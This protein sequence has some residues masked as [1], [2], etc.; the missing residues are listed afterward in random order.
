M[1]VCVCLTAWHHFELCN[2]SRVTIGIFWLMVVPYC[3]CL[4]MLYMPKICKTYARILFIKSVDRSIWRKCWICVINSFKEFNQKVLTMRTRRSGTITV[5]GNET[6]HKRKN[7]NKTGN[8]YYT[9]TQLTTV[10]DLTLWFPFYI[11]WKMIMQ[12]MATLETLLASTHS[13][14]EYCTTCNIRHFSLHNCQ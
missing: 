6:R 10:I 1:C 5:A 7:T 12:I 2:S 14:T 4:H 8:A 13:V 3:E 11:T 9:K